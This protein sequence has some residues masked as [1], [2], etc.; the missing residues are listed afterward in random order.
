M[1]SGNDEKK[2]CNFGIKNT[3]GCNLEQLYIQKKMYSE[4]QETEALWKKDN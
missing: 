1:S 3:K 4:A 2:Y